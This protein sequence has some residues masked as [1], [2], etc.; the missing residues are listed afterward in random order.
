MLI[1]YSQPVLVG[2]VAGLTRYITTFEG[3]EEYA[4]LD[5]YLAF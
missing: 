1:G 4:E 5:A 2:M 3:E